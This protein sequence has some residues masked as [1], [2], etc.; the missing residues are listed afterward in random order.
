MRPECGF[1]AALS[2]SLVVTAM[3]VSLTRG[4]T[5]IMVEV[6]CWLT[7]VKEKMMAGGCGY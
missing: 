1:D 5:V 7:M 2:T 6:M 4:D 3:V